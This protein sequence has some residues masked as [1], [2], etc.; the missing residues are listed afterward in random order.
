LKRLR[1]YIIASITFIINIGLDRIGKYL[2]SSLLKGNN[3]VHVIGNLFILSYIENEG[4]FLSFGSNWPV[5]LKIIVFLIVPIVVCIGTFIYV[6]LKEEK[7][8]RIILI[9]TIIS[10][11]IGNLVDRLFN[12]FKVV[13][14][15]NFGIGRLRTEI[16]NIAD[17]S[18]TFGVIVFIMIELN[19]SKGKDKTKHELK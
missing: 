9:T 4:A 19:E 18:I 7:I 15:M 1:L 11:G 3:S 17:L 8:Y 5:F 6:L 12:D 13:D 14:F 10:G 2:A 16:L